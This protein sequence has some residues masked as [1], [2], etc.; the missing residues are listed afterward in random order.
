MLNAL[1]SYEEDFV[2]RMT[3]G[4]ASIE[5]S[6]LTLQETALVLDHE[7]LPKDIKQRDDMMS[8]MGIYDAYTFAM[9]QAVE[10]RTLDRP[11][12]QDIH[13]H[14]AIDMDTSVRGIFRHIPV[15]IKGSTTVPPV[16][17][18]VRELLD[19]LIFLYEQSKLHPLAAIA[20]SHKAFESIHPFVDGNG[21]TGRVL[22]NFQLV[23]R[24]YPPI[25][26]DADSRQRYLTAL[27]DWTVSQNPVSLVS[28]ICDKVIE[29]SKRRI[30]I[31]G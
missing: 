7:F 25:T 12:I 22:M 20:A 11:L 8:S 6:T 29:E 15:Y 10:G 19:D 16:A 3:H 21:R 31:L 27:E 17:D 24:G 4:S 5:G 28:L 2:V 26:V 1:Q 13:E 14:V 23:T 30:E 18:K 9:R